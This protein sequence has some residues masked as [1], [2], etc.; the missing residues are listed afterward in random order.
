M[1]HAVGLFD[2]APENHRRVVTPFL[3]TAMESCK[4]LHPGAVFDMARE[5]LPECEETALSET[6]NGF[7]IFTQKRPS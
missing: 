4:L 5:K 6:F 1:Q 7:Y 2:E 3:L